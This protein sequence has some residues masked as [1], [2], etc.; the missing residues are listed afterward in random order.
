MGL[1]PS[2]DN[3][4]SSKFIFPLNLGTVKANQ[5]FTIQMAI[6]N[7]ETGKFTNPDKNYFAAPQ[8]LNSQGIIV[9][10]SHVV[11]QEISSFNETTTLDPKKFAFFSALNSAA[12]NG[13]LKVTVGGG[14]PV[15]TYKLSSINTAANHQPALVPIAQHGS[16]DDAI[17][18]SRSVIFDNID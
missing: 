2:S 10:H 3:M 5:N 12:V 14:L 16:L 18:V 4:P 7:L 15:G 6:N 9:G 8:Q 13:V 17:Y 1:I 11:I